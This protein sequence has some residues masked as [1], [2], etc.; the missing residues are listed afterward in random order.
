MTEKLKSWLEND[1]N[2]FGLLLIVVALAS[3][4]LGQA[5]ASPV[6]SGHESNSVVISEA[7]RK[8]APVDVDTT[9]TS[10]VNE[11][12]KLF[13]ASKNGTKYHRDDC[14]GASQIKPENRIEFATA[15]AATAA[16]YTPAAN[17]PPVE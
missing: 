3:F 12:G 11:P 9:S 1:R 4:F 16:G 5:A 15:A 10:N 8:S 7:K 6:D 13:V 14:P 17:C 2:F